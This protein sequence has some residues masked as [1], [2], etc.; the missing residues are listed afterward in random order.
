MTGSGWMRLG[1]FV[2]FIVGGSGLASEVVNQ[3][4]LQ[5]FLVLLGFAL[6]TVMNVWMSWRERQ[7]EDSETAARV[8]NDSIP[9]VLYLRTFDSDVTAL[10]FMIL[11]FHTC[12]LFAGSQFR[13]F[14]LWRRLSRSFDATHGDR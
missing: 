4:A 1:G 7:Q 14:G 11:N 12:V 8:V 5:L 13:N 10:N 9:D 6:F 2:V 3:P